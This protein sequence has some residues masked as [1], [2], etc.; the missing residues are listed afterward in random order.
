M[1]IIILLTVLLS[2]N[3]MTIGVVSQYDTMRECQADEK[4]VQKMDKEAKTRCLPVVIE[5]YSDPI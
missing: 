3:P 2:N 4:K 5:G 1:K